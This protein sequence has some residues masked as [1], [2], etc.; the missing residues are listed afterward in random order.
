MSHWNPRGDPHFRWRGG[1]VSRVEGFSDAVFGFALTLLVVSLEAP[2]SYADLINALR[3]TG[4]F[5][6]CFSLLF[7]VWEKHHRFFRRYGLQDAWTLFLNG[8]LLFIV[9]LYVYPLRF[10][11]TAFVDG[12]LLRRPMPDLGVGEMPAVFTIYGV[13]FLAIFGVFALLHAH[14]L[15]H[16]DELQMTPLEAALTRLEVWRAVLTAAVALV[17][18]VLAELLPARLVGIAGYSYSL[19]GL[20]EFWHGG[21]AGKAEAAHAG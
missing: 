12:V 5:A 4:V 18:I 1:E 15:R 3:E 14:A 20:V 9:M 17:S 2:K 16:F 11:S 6:F 19:I 7:V 10:L 8:L 21:A 13:G